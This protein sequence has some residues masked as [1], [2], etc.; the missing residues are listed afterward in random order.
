MEKKYAKPL[1]ELKDR[2]MHREISELISACEKLQFEIK[3]IPNSD[4]TLFFMHYNSTNG[5][6]RSHMAKLA[7]IL[8]EEDFDIYRFEKYLKDSEFRWLRA[9]LGEIKHHLNGKEV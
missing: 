3:R 6:Y 2:K 9:N 5:E 4:D 1:D 7:D 8:D